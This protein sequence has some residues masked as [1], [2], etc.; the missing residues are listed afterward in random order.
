MT[1][2]HEDIMAEIRA[3]KEKMIVKDDLI[4]IVGEIAEM[5][6]SQEKT[7]ELVE[8]LAFVKTGSKLVVWAS[9]VTAAVIAVWVV[10]KGGADFLMEFGKQ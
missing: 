4:P 7:K 2:S 8:A 9:K 6:E 1:V 3:M 5:K 10:V